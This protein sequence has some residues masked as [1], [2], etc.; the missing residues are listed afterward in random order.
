VN[1]PYY[2][3]VHDENDAASDALAAIRAEEAEGHITPRQAAAE[4]CS[5]LRQHL[6]RLHNLRIT[7]LGGEA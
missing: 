3:A 1:D 6:D 4:R 2:A 7:Y 5:L